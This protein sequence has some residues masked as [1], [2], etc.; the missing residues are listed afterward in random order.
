[1]EGSIIAQHGYKFGRKASILKG[2]SLVE[3]LVVISIIAMLMAILVPV[4][5][6][7][8]LKARTLLKMS[9][10]GQIVG[11]VNCY[12]NEHDDK[13]PGSTAV[14]GTPDDWG[15]NDPRMLIGIALLSPGERRSMS[16]YL[17]GYIND[18]GVMFC[19]N[20]P[21]KYKYLEE[22]WGAGDDWAIPGDPMP[23]PM[24]GTYCFYWN[25]IGCLDD[26]EVFRGP[27]GPAG[28]TGQGSVLVSDYFG[29]DHIRSRY[30]YGSCEPVRG[31][32]IT[33]ETHTSSAY[34]S[35]H[36]SGGMAEAGGRALIELHAGYLDGHV[37]KY[38]PADV[39]SMQ[40]SLH[41]DGLTPHYYFGV[42]YLPKDGLD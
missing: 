41:S 23:S 22:A 28:G 40:A 29:Y 5:G 30:C 25:Y 21:K 16:E 34:W 10:Q 7:A 27:S 18:A 37:G 38:S 1:M 42:F 15:S 31:A 12:A 2:F 32:K 39:A 13:Y 26:G 11:A 36:D 3:L 14:T 20:A 4:L 19:P 35:W 17:R 24:I 9:N 8:R 33:D 6:K